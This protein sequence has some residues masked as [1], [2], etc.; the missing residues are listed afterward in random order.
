M[1]SLPSV[2]ATG[3]TVET[4]ISAGL[5]QLGVGPSDVIVEVIDEPSRGVFGIGARPARVRVKLLR[6][7]A[8]PP[9]APPLKTS[10]PAAAP[11]PS[12]PAPSQPSPAVSSEID[13]GDSYDEDMDEVYLG[14]ATLGEAVDQP[15][16]D[17]L[18]GKQVLAEL[19]FKMGIE[20]EVTIRHTDP[21][22]PGEHAPWLLDV[23]GPDVSLLIGRRGDTLAALQYIT[24]LIAS[25]KLQRRANIIVDVGGY[26]SR[27]SQRLRQLAV[28]MADQAVKQ[29]RT[30]SLEPMPPNERRIVHLTLRNRTDVVTK[31]TG[32]GE[33]RKVTIVPK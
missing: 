20:A 30:V 5:A 9:A 6:P 28:R 4:A 23:S 18:V 13:Y 2:E 7:P 1:D 15:D 31:S 10:P 17:G 19:L 16:E 33:A 26:K 21:S 22:R 25:R 12:R 32:E 29:A 11:Q 24:R 8:P 3:D 14:E 27:R